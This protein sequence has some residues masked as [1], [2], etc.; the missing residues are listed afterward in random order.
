LKGTLAKA[1][2]ATLAAFG[3]Y[4]TRT[5]PDAT[6]ASIEDR[7]EIDFFL[8]QTYTAAAGDHDDPVMEWIVVVEQSQIDAFGRLIHLGRALHV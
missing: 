8:S 4:A 2:L 1:A 6:A 7:A 3:E 5:T